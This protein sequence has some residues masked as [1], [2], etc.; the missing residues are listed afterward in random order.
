MWLLADPLDEPANVR[1]SLEG[2]ERVVLALEFLVVEDSVYMPV[3][4]RAETY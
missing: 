1:V 4:G 3:V 2:L